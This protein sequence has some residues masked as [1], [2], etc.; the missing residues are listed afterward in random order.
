LKLRK[1]KTPLESYK[2]D[3]LR[4]DFNNDP[5]QCHAVEHTQRLFD[6]L[7]LKLEAEPAQISF[8]KRLF[9]TEQQKNIKAVKGLYFW[10]GVG[11]GKTYLVDNFYNS[12]PFDE[13]IRIHFHSFMQLVH[14]ELGTLKDVQ[15]PLSV[16][17]DRFSSK[18]RVICFDEFHVSDITDAMLL[19]KL[20]DNLFMRG[21]CLVATSNEHPDQ[22]YSGGLQ[23]DRFLPAID[24]IK[25][26]TEIVEVDSGIDYRFRLL[27]QAEIYHSPL[28]R[29]ANN[30]LSTSFSCLA[31]NEGLTD[32]PIE[33]LGRRINTVRIAD[34][35]VWFDFYEICGGPRSAADYIEI[36]RIYHT[37]FI[38][39]IP[40]MDSFKDDQAKR[41]MTIID[42][43]YDRNV[44]VI[45]SAAALPE[46]L[47]SGTRLVK[48]FKRTVSRLQEMGS[49]QY[50]KQQH[51]SE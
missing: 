35:L 51:I 40:V 1:K 7:V 15:D 12:L 28:D 2:A 45:I 42:E 13:K 47:Y 37:V 19:G 22:L 46:E 24:L 26:N 38:S 48:S 16:V 32:Q 30:S 44:N 36:A 4:E 14:A 33:V 3:L 21:V 20:F 27:E 23:R 29:S 5:A 6:D 9:L 17:A 10:G 8:I 34:G 50:L 49:T 43:F 18:A 39:D 31:C 41:F 11:R 25:S